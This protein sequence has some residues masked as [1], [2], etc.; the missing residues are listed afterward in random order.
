[1]EALDI[2]SLNQEYLI[3]TNKSNTIYEDGGVFDS[4]VQPIRY[5]TLS[6]RREDVGSSIISKEQS[7]DYSELPDIQLQRDS[8]GL[9]QRDVNPLYLKSQEDFEYVENMKKLK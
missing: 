6:T 8:I 5:T 7:E 1:M 4:R 3:F 2:F 9:S